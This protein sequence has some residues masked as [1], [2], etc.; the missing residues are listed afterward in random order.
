LRVH[1]TNISP[2]SAT[3]TTTV[4]LN[5][6]PVIWKNNI[7]DTTIED[8]KDYVMTISVS[9]PN[10]E[11]MTYTKTINISVQRDDIV[12]KLLITPDTVGT[13]PFT[14]NFDASTTTVN[15][16]NDEIIY[17]SRDF[18]D[19]NTEINTSQSI[20]KHTY[21]YDY[22]HEN[23]EYHPTVKLK[24][25]NGREVSIW[26]TILVKKPVDS[27]IISLDSHPA[28]VA[29][30]WDKVDMSIS[31]NWTPTKIIRDFWNWNTLECKGR[32]CTDTSQVFS[33]PGS[34]EIKVT[35]SYSN[36][37]DVEWSINLVV[38]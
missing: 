5:W 32:E 26:D 9:D 23:W 22:E 16:T 27:V 7:F 14:V 29:M 38:R 28:Q 1:I 3:T 17:F 18:W 33:E 20:I 13:A 21:N 24:T 2:S 15:N 36:R 35:V 10:H 4:T 37:T 11:E 8:T 34:Y 25:K 30:A 6:S 19:W 12:P 31:I